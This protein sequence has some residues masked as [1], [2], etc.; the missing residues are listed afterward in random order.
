MTPNEYRQI[1]AEDRAEDR[2]ALKRTFDRWLLFGVGLPLL[3]VCLLPVI[4]LLIGLPRT[5]SPM[6]AAWHRAEL[7]DLERSQK[8]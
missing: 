3:I 5:E 6:Q 1:Q 4:G 2:K 8:P 7:R